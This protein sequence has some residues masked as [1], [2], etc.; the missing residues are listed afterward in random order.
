M[1]AHLDIR[2]TSGFTFVEAMIALSLLSVMFLAV[3]QTSSRASDAFDEGS[4]DHLLSTS[5]HRALDRMSGW[6]ELSDASILAANTGSLTTDGG[7]ERVDFQV[8]VAFEGTNVTW[9]QVSIFAELEPGEQDDAQ[10]ND[11]DGLVDELQIVEV[12]GVGS[13]EE[14]RSVLAHGVTELFEGELPN[15]ADDNGNGLKDEAGLSFSADGDVV[16][17]RLSCQ[18]RGEGGRLLAKTAETAVRLRN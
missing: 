7:D 14:R 5:T 11:G 15:D 4:A 8:P 16:T 3:A 10:D 2:R 18:R 13:P 17:L 1:K 12:Q 9:L 6:I